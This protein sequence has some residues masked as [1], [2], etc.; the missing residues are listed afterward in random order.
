MAVAKITAT[1]AATKVAMPTYFI[2]IYPCIWAAAPGYVSWAAPL[3]PVLGRSR[4][5]FLKRRRF[6]GHRLWRR[7]CGP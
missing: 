6:A 4:P 7:G 3:Q 1:L 5:D 2:F